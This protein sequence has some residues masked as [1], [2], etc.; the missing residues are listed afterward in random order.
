MSD[1]PIVKTAGPQGD[2]GDTGDTGA[3]GTA[4]T[5]DAGTT[6][7][8]APGS[9]ATVTNVGTTA[10]AIFDFGIPQGEAGTGGGGVPD[11]APLNQTLRGDGTSWVASSIIW[12]QVDRVNVTAPLLVGFPTSQAPLPNIDLSVNNGSIFGGGMTTEGIIS[13]G[14][15]VNGQLSADIIT[16]DTY[17]PVQPNEAVTKQYVDAQIGGPSFWEASGNDIQNTNSGSVLIG[18]AL[19]AGATLLTQATITSAQG[20]GAGNLTRYDY[21]N[22]QLAG[23]VNTTDTTVVRTTGAQTV[24]SKTLNGVTM[25]GTWNP[26][27]LTSNT[28]QFVMCYVGGSMHRGPLITTAAQI[29][30]LVLGVAAALNASPAQMVAVEAAL[31]ANSLSVSD[32]MA[33]P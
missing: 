9:P 27:S 33:T 22:G 30:D 31:G 16:I 17:P 26:N 10:A 29:R 32:V 21:V 7:T 6:T 4:A 25:T 23:K 13:S 2:T 5:V 18:G 8:L 12:N 20:T 28:S 15:V 3:D 14:I 24:S 1:S 19:F 11:P